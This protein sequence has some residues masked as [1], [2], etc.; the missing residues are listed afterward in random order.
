MVCCCR[1]KGSNAFDSS[2]AR[3]DLDEVF[4]SEDGDVIVLPRALK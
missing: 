3:I 4:P 1:V 2:D